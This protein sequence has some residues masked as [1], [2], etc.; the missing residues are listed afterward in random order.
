MGHEVIAGSRVR[1]KSEGV[2]AEIAARWGDVVSG[3]SAGTNAE[4]AEAGDLVVVATNWE[5]VVPTAQAHAAALAAKP[6]VC[7]GNGLERV[8]HEFRA[9]L[10][11]QGSLAV[12]VAEAVPRSRVAAAFQLV[13]ASAF[14]ALDRP[15]H[16]DVV[17][18]ADD[19]DT[20]V[21]VMDLVVGVPELRAF[22]GGSLRNAGGIEAFAAVLLTVN[23]RHK[24]K[25]TLTLRDAEGWPHRR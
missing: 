10:P 13:P 23:V 8:D 15:L 22:D 17:V 14:G 16:S 24:A 20:R 25:G 6:V 12:A 1:S 2:V 11:E 18:C 19:E 9:V 21:M 3:L 7:M 4:A 5:A